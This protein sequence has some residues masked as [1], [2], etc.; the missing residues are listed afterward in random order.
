LAVMGDRV[1]TTNAKLVY[2]DRLP[3]GSAV[4]WD[5]ASLVLSAR[6]DRRVS[7]AEAIKLGVEGPDGFYVTFRRLALVNEP[8]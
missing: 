6:L 2:L 3:I 5:D 1:P 4:S 8:L 7:V